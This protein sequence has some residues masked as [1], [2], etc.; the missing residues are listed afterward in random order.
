[1]G[2]RRQI[3]S[4]PIKIKIAAIDPELP[5]AKTHRPAGVQDLARCIQKRE[6]QL[7]NVA[8]RMQ[9]PELLRFPFRTE[10]RAAVLDLATAKRIT[11]ELLNGLPSLI[12]LG[13]QY[14]LPVGGEPH[15][16]R[17]TRYLPPAHRRLHPQCLDA[18]GRW[19]GNQV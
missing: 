13:V 3:N 2:D 19:R 5:E 1:Q 17:A 10:Y 18:G 14:I 9:V 8:G 16:V 6:P 4:A 15:Q 12:N 11:L 7:V